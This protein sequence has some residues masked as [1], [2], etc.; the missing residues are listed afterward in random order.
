[1]DVIELITRHEGD[2]GFP[3]CDR[4]GARIR[5]YWG[6]WECDCTSKQE[7]PGNL[8]IGRGH[9]LDARELP[10]AIRLAL[11]QADLIDTVANL[12][13]FSWFAAL[14][15][16]RQAALI[17]LHFNIGATRFREFARMIDAVARGD[18]RAAAAEMINSEWA[19]EV[20]RRAALDSTLLGS[21]EWP[22]SQG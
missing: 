14:D 11:L 19:R 15:G 1:M 7:S 16:V 9:N 13:T 10:E 18:Y 21:G 20:P 12:K 3:Y 6:G 5:R 22:D 2:R 17:D 4:C 8:T